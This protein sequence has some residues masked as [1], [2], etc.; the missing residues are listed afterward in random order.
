MKFSKGFKLN[1]DYGLEISGFQKI[2]DTKDGIDFWEFLC[3]LDLYDNDHNPSFQI[4]F[5]VCNIK[6]FE[7]MIYNL[8][9]KE[10]E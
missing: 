10:N 5:I 8:H 4:M 2:R 7:F 3:N 9:H 6:L 1:E